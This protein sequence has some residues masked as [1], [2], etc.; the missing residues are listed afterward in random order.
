MFGSLFS[1]AVLCFIL[2]FNKPFG[3]YFFDVLNA[4]KTRPAAGLGSCATRRPA[5]STILFTRSKVGF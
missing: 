5:T 1:N 2:V 3:V 4:R